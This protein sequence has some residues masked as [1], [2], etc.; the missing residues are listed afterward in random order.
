MTV[1]IWCQLWLELAILVSVAGSLAVSRVR[2]P[3]RAWRWGLAFTG[4][5]LVLSL[6]A[7]LGFY[8]CRIGEVSEGWSFQANLIGKQWFRLDELSAPLA[9]L[10]ALLHFLTALATGRTKMR[11]FSLSLSL[12]C[13]AFALAAF[14]SLDS[15]LLVTLLCVGVVPGYLELRNR[16][17]PTRLYVLHMATFVGL[18]VVGRAFVDPTSDLASRPLW[19]T[20]PLAA[21]I[22]IR[23]GC[24]PAHCW[25]TDWFENASL[26]NAL[27]FVAPQAGVYAAVRL[28][29]PIAPDWMLQGI[30][31][32]SL[33][34]AVYAAGM[35]VVQRD[36]RRWYAYLFLSHAALILVGL[37][38]HTAIGLTGALSLWVSVALSLAGLGLT[39]RALEAR[40]GRLS[41]TRF[42]GLYDHSPMLAVCFLMTGLASVGFPGTFGFVAMELLTDGAVEVSPIVGL[43][44]AL[45]AA[46]NGIAVVRAYF[47]LFTGARHTSTVS[48]SMT[49]RERLAVLTLAVLILGGGLLPQPFV[50]SRFQAS[51]SILS[52]RERRR[53]EAARQITKQSG[54]KRDDEH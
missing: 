28:V 26:G 32:A 34:T 23:C 49:L 17:K 2:D 6:L 10:V 51:E 4:A 30:G 53:E 14:S 18:M 54:F 8:L 1:P 38:L 12:A 47:Y 48:L 13:E 11:R 3:L 40:F 41:L 16:G 43:A 35:A 27:L 46:I 36:S 21:A 33:V 7:S 39:L 15:W 45:T 44:I 5:S 25:I 22:L 24:V 37:E 42:H 31:L 29:V 20:I 50:S 52:D 19:A 9:P